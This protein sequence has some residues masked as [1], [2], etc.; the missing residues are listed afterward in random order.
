MHV[1][2]KKALATAL[3]NLDGVTDDIVA[4]RI[5]PEQAASEYG[6]PEDMGGE[7]K[8]KGLEVSKVQVMDGED[9]SEET[10]IPGDLLEQLK[11]LLSQ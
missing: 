11:A 9:P 7:M 1:D 5:R 2:L 3:Q 4:K 6:D 10:E 8:P